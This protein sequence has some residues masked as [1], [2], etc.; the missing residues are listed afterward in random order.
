VPYIGK[1]PSID[2]LYV[3][4]GHFRN[5]IVLG[6]ASARLLADIVLERA[7]ILDPSV[8]ALTAERA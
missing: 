6:L 7:P 2:G 8:Y 1:H 5:G 4:T 3:N